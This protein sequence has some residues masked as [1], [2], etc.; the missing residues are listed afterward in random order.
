[1]GVGDG[2]LHSSGLSG[3]IGGGAG[4]RYA[5]F[6]SPLLLLIFVSQNSLMQLYI[7][8]RFLLHH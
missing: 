4:G 6:S 7:I 5:A 2:H 3:R 1:M 8:K